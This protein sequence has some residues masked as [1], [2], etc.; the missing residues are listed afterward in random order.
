MFRDREE[1][2]YSLAERLKGRPLQ[3]PLVL[4]IPR[5][6]IVIG[7]VLARE[8]DAELDVVLSRKLRMPLQPELAVGAVAEDGSVYLNPR[9][10]FLDDLLG[11]Y[12]AEEKSIQFGE[13]ARRE[14]LFRSVRPRAPIAGRSV[15]VTDD[16][17]ATGATM[18]AAL[19]S[20]KNH[21]PHGVIVAVPVATTERVKEMR[22]WCDDVVCL[23]QPAELRAV[24]QFY[25]NFEPVEDS[26]VLEVLRQ[27]MRPNTSPK[28]P[29][30]SSR[31]EWI[32]S[33]H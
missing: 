9:G 11:D 29:V 26:T 5:G 23:L 30:N 17:I 22:R 27:A 8:L 19:Q 20:L 31:A 21:D 3:S 7:A 32:A 15:I 33:A 13:I 4:A 6:G 24:G 2:G 10:D 1:A 12:L 25:E 16:G 18:I 14:R 28:D